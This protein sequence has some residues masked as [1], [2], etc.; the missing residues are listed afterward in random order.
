M[1]VHTVEQGECLLVIAHKYGFGSWHTVYDHARNAELRKQRPNPNILA[2]GDK[3][4]IPDKLEKEASVSTGALHRFQVSIERHMLRL[5]LKN[6]SGR[7][8]AGKKYKLQV[9]DQTSEG[10]TDDT[11][12]VEQEI[13]GGEQV[14]TLLMWP[15]S[16]A[17]APLTWKLK[18]GELDPVDEITGVQARLNNLGFPCG[19]VDG[20]HGPQTEAA[21]KEFQGS[22]GLE[23][24]GEVD[25][26][27][28]NKLRDMHEHGA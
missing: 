22:C 19:A 23:Q 14:G 15:G 18:L 24:T 25:D 26:A 10:V 16:D 6:N 28:R 17:D 3:V 21:L 13:A 8:Y 9:G 7:P 4:Y 12:L 27:T 5:V 20:S 11:G 2:P 1:S